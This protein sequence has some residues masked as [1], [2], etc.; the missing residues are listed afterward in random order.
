MEFVK[1]ESAENIAKAVAPSFADTSLEVLTSA[2]ANYK[3][4]GAYVDDMKLK[5]D[6][7]EHLQDII[8]AAGVM[9][10]RADYDKLVNNGYLG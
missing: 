1:N 9:T 5:K 4:I 8:I 3:R 6:D 10:K 7:F 2:I